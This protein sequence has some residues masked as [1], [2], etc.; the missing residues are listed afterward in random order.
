[1]DWIGGSSRRNDC[2]G[3]MDRVDHLIPAPLSS[4]LLPRADS[5]PV[6]LGLIMSRRHVLT[7]TMQSSPMAGT[8]IGYIHLNLRLLPCCS[9]YLNFSGKTL[10]MGRACGSSEILGRR[11]TLLTLSLLPPSQC[12]GVL[13]LESRAVL[14]VGSCPCGPSKW[15]TII[16]TPRSGK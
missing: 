5:L 6:P 1:M 13:R 8:L 9:L 3:G 16:L 15:M 10:S 4:P 11:C 12:Q 7:A 14:L 2:R